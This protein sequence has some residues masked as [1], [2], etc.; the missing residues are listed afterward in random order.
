MQFRSTNV[1][2]GAPYVVQQFGETR[3]NVQSHKK[4]GFVAKNRKR[5]RDLASEVTLKAL[6]RRRST[7]ASIACVGLRDS[8]RS[9]E[10]QKLP[11]LRGVWNDNTRSGTIDTPTGCRVN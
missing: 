9:V 8:F 4:R 3:V 6:A 5:K 1:E 2:D 7:D 10:A 11:K